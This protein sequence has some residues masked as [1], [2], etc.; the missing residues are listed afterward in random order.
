MS[1]ALEKYVPRDGEGIPLKKDG[2]M[3]ERSIDG[4]YNY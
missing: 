2:Q 1:I 3:G 4:T